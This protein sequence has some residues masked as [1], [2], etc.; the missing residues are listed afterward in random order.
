MQLIF[1][2]ISHLQDDIISL[3]GRERDGCGNRWNIRELSFPCLI[4]DITQDFPTIIVFRF[5]IKYRHGLLIPICSSD[6]IGN[7]IQNRFFTISTTFPVSQVLKMMELTFQ[8]LTTHDIFS[9]RKSWRK[10]YIYREREEALDVKHH[11]NVASHSCSKS[12]IQFRAEDVYHIRLEFL[13]HFLEL[14][15]VIRP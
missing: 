15:L 8:S 2:D 12:M 3:I 11:W 6:D 1:Q 4:K 9:T 10:E 7:C 13:N 14:L 5:W